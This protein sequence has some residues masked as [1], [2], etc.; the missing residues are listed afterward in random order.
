ML[1]T[2]A[3]AP[4]VVP[5]VRYA[6]VA[7]ATQVASPTSP[8]A[9]DAPDATFV[10]IPA[11]PD[12]AFLRAPGSTDP[13]TGEASP[14]ATAY[15]LAKTPVTNAQYAA[16]LAATP[17]H[18]A[19]SAWENGEIP[20]GK[21]DHPV[22]WVSSNDAKAYCDWLGTQTSGWAFRLPTEAEWEYAARGDTTDTW[23][24]GPESG[25]TWDGTS[26]TAHYTYNGTQVAWYLLNEPDTIATY[27]DEKSSSYGETVRLGG[28]LSMDADGIV[29]DACWADYETRTGFVYTD[30]FQA[31]A[32]AADFTTPVGAHPENASPFGC[33]DMSGNVCEWTSTLV[34]AT[35]GGEAGQAGQ[36]AIRGGSWYAAAKNCEGTV[37][38]EGRDPSGTGVYFSVGFRVAAERS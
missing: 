26:F 12:F 28:L 18:A 33:L 3:T 15:T 22:M 37:R 14:I 13:G 10:A 8:D 4:F 11:N 5:L 24:W 23:P 25:T 36:Q 9:G 30:I 21:D 17:S 32:N 27:T 38:G 1:S 16:F 2:F 35:I 31:R 29:P 34:D 7:A 20:A 19:P 6:P